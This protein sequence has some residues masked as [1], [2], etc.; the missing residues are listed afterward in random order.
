MLPTFESETGTSLTTQF[1]III[2][3]KVK[4][5]MLYFIVII[6]ISLFHCLLQ[7]TSTAEKAANINRKT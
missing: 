7:T 6:I 2:S 4:M 1:Q 5:N 3:S